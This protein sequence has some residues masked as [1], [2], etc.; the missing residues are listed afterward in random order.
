[1]KHNFSKNACRKPCNPSFES[2]VSSQCILHPILCLEIL[3]VVLLGHR[4]RLPSKNSAKYKPFNTFNTHLSTSNS[5]ISALGLDRDMG[6]SRGH[7]GCQGHWP[8]NDDDDEEEEDEVED[9]DKGD[10]N[11][12]DNNDKGISALGLDR[13]LGFSRGHQGRQGHRP[14]D[15]DNNEEDDDEVEDNDKDDD[16]NKDDNDD[17]GISALGLDRD[18]GFL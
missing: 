12:D 13:D 7:Q 17:K 3:N 10:N 16:N 8:H 15:D 2:L 11:K 1:M 6:F 4:G 5:N 14:H 18:L 9:N